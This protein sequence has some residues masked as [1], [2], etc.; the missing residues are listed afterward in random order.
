MNGEIALVCVFVSSSA[1]WGGLRPHAT[2][3]CVCEICGLNKLQQ[4][5]MTKSNLSSSV[6]V[7]LLE[8]AWCLILISWKWRHT[9]FV[10][11]VSPPPHYRWTELIEASGYTQCGGHFYYMMSGVWPENGQAC[12]VLRVQ[13]RIKIFHF[14]DDNQ[15]PHARYDGWLVLTHLSRIKMESLVVWLIAHCLC[16]LFLTSQRSTRSRRSKCER[17]KK[18]ND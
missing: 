10:Q 8:Y 12:D 14:L 6:S 2:C 15:K 7:T 11:F 13:M 16:V 18:S 1:E 4:F 17:R 9:V 5:G 3:V